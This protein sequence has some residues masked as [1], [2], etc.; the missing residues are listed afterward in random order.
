MNK[1]CK[2]ENFSTSKP[3]VARIRATLGGD[4]IKCH[5]PGGVAH[6]TD[7]FKVL[8]FNPSGVV[9]FFPMLPR[10]ARIR[11]TLGFDVE[12]PWSL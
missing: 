2:I 1:V 10:V 5:N 6:F 11:A 8:L 12:L 4:A 9:H 7:V 3:R